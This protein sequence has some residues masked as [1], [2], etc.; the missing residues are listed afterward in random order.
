MV[1][2]PVFPSYGRVSLEAL[3]CDKPVVAY[4]SN[5]HAT[6]KTEPYD[7]DDMAE[8]IIQCIEEK[9]TGHRKYAEKHLDAMDMAKEAIK[10]YNK[11]L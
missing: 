9:P 2:S 11:V 3:A 7:P 1:V 6:Y 5:P 8:K 4:K 10:I